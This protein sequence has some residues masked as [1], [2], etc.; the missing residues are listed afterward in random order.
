M[1]E[2]SHEASPVTVSGTGNRL[3][4]VVMDG[5]WGCHDDDVTE[6]PIGIRIF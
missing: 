5:M 6:Q 1:L 4:L 2:Y 3:S